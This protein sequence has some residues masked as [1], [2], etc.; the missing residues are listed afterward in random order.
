VA[1]AFDSGQPKP[2]TFSGRIRS[3]L[4]PTRPDRFVFVVANRELNH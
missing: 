2:V 1:L 3:G 4:L